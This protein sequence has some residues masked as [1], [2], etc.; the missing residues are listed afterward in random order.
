MRFLLAALVELPNSTK[1]PVPTTSAPTTT[2]V[3]KRI[4]LEVS[5]A[6]SPSLCE[7]VR[8]WC[9]EWSSGQPAAMGGRVYLRP[10]VALY[11]SADPARRPARRG[12]LSP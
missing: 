12:S 2:A 9:E 10:G 5:I 6:P 4:R 8:R 11:A 3:S 1:E 7:M